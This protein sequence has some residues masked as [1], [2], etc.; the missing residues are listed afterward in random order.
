MKIFSGAQIKGWDDFSIREQGI[1][2]GI[3]MEQAAAAC[4]QWLVN[5]HFTTKPLRIFCG[6]GNNGGDGLAIARMLIK[7]GISVKVYILELGKTGS[8]D[9]QAN[10]HRLHEL[11]KEIHFIQSENFFPAVEQDE[12]IVDALFG[13][14]LNKPLDGLALKLVEYLNKCKSLKISIDIPS[15]LFCDKSTSGHTALQAT[16]TLSF[17]SIKLCFLLPENQ[18]YVGTFHILDIGLSKTY[19]QQEHAVHEVVDASVIKAIIRPRNKFSNKGNF[20]HAALVAGSYGMM[21]ACVLAARA[22]MQMG[23]G[24]LTCHIP[25]CG[26]SIIQT[27]LPEAMC[28]VDGEKFIS[29]L[30]N[31]ER[32]S[33]VGIGP[34]IG[35]YDATPA[36]MEGIFSS[37]NKNLVLD[38]DALN[39]LAGEKILLEKVPAGIVITPHP[40][41]FDRMFGKPANDFERLELA[42]TKAAALQIYIVLKG[43]HTAVVTPKGKVYFNDTGNAGMAK[44]GM[45]DVLTGMI[46]GLLAQNYPLPEAAMLAVYLHGMAGDLAAAKYS[47][48]AMLATDLVNCIPEAWKALTP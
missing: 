7:T 16:H 18:E 17:E 32:Y 6:K 43:H 8:E 45:G 3:L 14:G 38:A 44:A 5:N 34:G 28:K 31:P 33:A 29:K 37:G 9:F 21:G 12:L 26:Y 47:Q 48:N 36:L 19:E 35:V 11:S 46:T 2:S 24:K 22:C 40:K 39:I 1:T 30:D 41:E 15:G 25:S 42:I 23:V 27:T 10:L 4:C 20:G 13:T